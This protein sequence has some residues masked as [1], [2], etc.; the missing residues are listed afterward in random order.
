MNPLWAY[1]LLT[2]GHL[3]FMTLGWNLTAGMGF[4]ARFLVLVVYLILG[5]FTYSWQFHQLQTLD[6]FRRKGLIYLL[7]MGLLITSLGFIALASIEIVT[8][9]LPLV[10][11]DPLRMTA[12]VIGTLLV[13]GLLHFLL[14]ILTLS[15]LSKPRS[16]PLLPAPNP[17]LHFL[18][19]LLEKKAAQTTPFSP[20][21]PSF[22]GDPDLPEPTL[23][24]NDDSSITEPPFYQAP[25]PIRFGEGITPAPQESA[26][27]SLNLGSTEGPDFLES[28]QKSRLKKIQESFSSVTNLSLFSYNSQ[29]ETIVSPSLEN[30]ICQLVQTSHKGVQHCKSHCGRS[31]GLALQSQEP[32]FFRCDMGLHVFTI[33]VITNQ[34][35]SRTNLALL[36]GKVFFDSQEFRH[37]LDMSDALGIARDELNRLKKSIRITK[38]QTLVSSARFL[39]SFLPTLLTTLYENSR[40]TEKSSRIMTLFNLLSQFKDESSLKHHAPSLLNTLGILFGLQTAS[41]LILQPE[42]GRFKTEAAFGQKSEVVSEFSPGSDAT[43]IRLLGKEKG[44]IYSSDT[45][46]ILNAGM[47]ADISSTRLFPLLIRNDTIHAVLAT[48][49]SILSDEEVGVIHLFCQQVA[50]YQEMMQLRIERQDLTKDM[51]VLLEIAKS[52]GSALES[53]DL[54]NIILEKSTGFLEAEQ[55]SLMILDEDR[56]ELKVKAMKGLNKKIVELLRIRP[57]EGI[58][59]MVLVNGDPILVSNLEE[60]IRIRQAKRPR[61]KTKSFISIPLRLNGEAFGVLNIAD[62]V[63]GENFSEDDLHLL[64]SIGAYASV[65][66]QR[67]QLYHKTEEL[68]KISITDELTGLLNRRYFQERIS[69]EIERSRRH[70]LPLSLI[71]LDM[72]NFKSINDTYGHV[73]GDEVLKVAGR[74]LRNSI[75]TIDVAVRYGGEEFTVILPQTTKEEAKVIADRICHEINKLDFPFEHPDI[76]FTAS[77]GLATLPEDADSIDELIRNADVALYQAKTEGKNRVVVYRHPSQRHD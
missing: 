2:L 5:P 8:F 21:F 75:R 42:D 1:K 73:V 51:A 36:G 23:S 44:P 50:I 68:K 74:C 17:N 67:S 65:A 62:K 66:I 24:E 57:G 70:H 76:P 41:I 19:D 60:D 31:I 9:D 6:D 63:A 16:K 58:A 48:F 25:N 34:L 28:D 59:G 33:P 38:N 37:G 22:S 14:A 11:Q 77:I 27:F 18:Q 54:F 20:T 56:N 53:E 71:M 40:A 35:D 15:A 69:E 45:R 29:G 32:I 12:I 52:A 7:G 72:D 39:E 46:E 43:L 47:S 13:L 49:D 61:Y 3:L 4:T 55:G 64:V 26:D 30:P 10:V